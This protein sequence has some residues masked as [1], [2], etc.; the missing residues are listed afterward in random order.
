MSL[1]DIDIDEALCRRVVDAEFSGDLERRRAYAIRR[2]RE[3]LAE[4]RCGSCGVR[5]RVN[6]TRCEPCRLEHAEGERLRKSAR[7]A[8]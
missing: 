1:S 6:R 3:I 8:A 2:W 5:P 7:K 4:G